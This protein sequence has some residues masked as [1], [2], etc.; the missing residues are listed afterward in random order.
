MGFFFHP[1]RPVGGLSAPS[2]LFRRLSLWRVIPR[3]TT[4]AI[5]SVVMAACGQSAQEKSATNLASGRV[6]VEIGG[7]RFDVPLR[8][9]YGHAI[10]TY[11]RWPTPKKDV[12]SMGALNLSV[13]LPDMRPYYKEDDARWKV[14]GHGERVEV[15][16]TN[17]RGPAPNWGRRKKINQEV[18]EKFIAEGRF[19]KKAPDIFELVHYSKKTGD[20]YFS[21]DRQL[22][23]NCDPALPLKGA[24]DFWSPSCKVKSDYLPYLVLEYYYALKYLPQWKEID[25]GLK[26]MFGQFASAAEN[27]STIK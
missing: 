8:Y 7:H 6:R 16:I 15:M 1:R 27:V 10:E 19:Y 18:I 17:F 12:A 3:T 23:I 25:D 21:S 9:L 11:G 14:K 4:L 22:Q 2:A 20:I 24:E 26:A 13:L 5:F